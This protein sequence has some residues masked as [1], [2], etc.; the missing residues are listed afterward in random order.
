MT[1]FGR[2]ES[3]GVLIIDEIDR[4]IEA[5]DANSEEAT[6]VIATHTGLKP[7]LLKEIVPPDLEPKPA[8]A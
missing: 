8:G 6:A 3:V 5:H 7:E 2:R 4:G 1:L